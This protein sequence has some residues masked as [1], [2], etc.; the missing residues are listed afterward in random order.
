MFQ[1]RECDMSIH[2]EVEFDCERSVLYQALT[3]AAAFA[4]ATGAP[5]EIE[6]IEGGTFSAFG[7]KITGRTIE[8]KTDRHIVQAWRV[9][10]WPEGVYSL[11]RLALDAHGE[12]TRLTLDQA[13]HPA[14]A[15]PHLDGG[16]QKM[17]WEPL[18]AHCK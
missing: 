6:P 14:D 12:K 11:V 7:G 4:E 13:G 9:A 16:W 1:E 15:E 3:N 17:Y 2:Q 10:D 18:K 5:A 8:L